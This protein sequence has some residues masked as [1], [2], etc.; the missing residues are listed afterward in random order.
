MNNFILGAP[1]DTT[2]H[3]LTAAPSSLA[4]LVEQAIAATITM[5]T[6]KRAVDGD[7]ETLA[8]LGRTIAVQEGYLIEA[9]IAA[10]ASTH[11][12]RLSLTGLR[13]PVLPAAMDLVKKNRKALY[14]GLSLDATMASSA[15]YYPDLVI[16]DPRSRCAL[17]LDVKR[18]LSGYIGGSKLGEL[19]QRMTASALVLPDLLWRD[20][21]RLAV[22]TVGTAIIDASK[23]T[24]DVSDGIWPLSRLDELLQVQHASLFASQSIDAFRHGVRTVWRQAIS[25][26]S[27]ASARPDAS[28]YRTT[29][30]TMPTAPLDDKPRA[31]RGR[32][33]K[34]RPS[35]KVGL[36]GPG[37]LAH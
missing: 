7:P 22:E 12:T 30:D 15:T 2:P 16:A 8:S 35:I 5:E 10:L 11:P 3:A 29:V 26:A 13:L 19:Q 33:P 21:Q 27:Q 4:T 32:P 31:R 6:A 37:L 36:I 18:S 34:Q 1:A 25:E 28:L 24:T 20:H 23:S 17:I 9:V 14:Q